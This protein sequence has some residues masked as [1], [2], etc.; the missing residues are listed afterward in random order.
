MNDDCNA[1]WKFAFFLFAIIFK[2]PS[3][4]V[5]QNFPQENCLIM[6]KW[7]LEW[8][9]DSCKN[10]IF[11]LN[12]CN[13]SQFSS[14]QT[15]VSDFFCYFRYLRK[16]KSNNEI[17]KNGVPIL[18]E[19]PTLKVFPSPAKLSPVCFRIFYAVKSVPGIVVPKRYCQI[20]RIR[21][22]GF[23]CLCI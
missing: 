11:E 5:Y 2:V 1:E 4:E 12:D 23:S 6:D 3:R 8:F 15:I 13:S 20:L 9:N 10:Y 21:R 18:R 17:L 7:F 19:V 14:K 16:L 22:S